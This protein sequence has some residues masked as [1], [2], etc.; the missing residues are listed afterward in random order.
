VQELN[1]FYRFHPALFVLDNDIAGFRWLNCISAEKCMLSFMRFSR[2]EEENLVIVANFA[3]IKQDFEIGVPIEG[4][5]YEVFNTDQSQYGG[6]GRTNEGFRETEDRE[7]DD[8]PHS[9]KMSAAPL[10]LS[11]FAYEPYTEE[12]LNDLQRKKESQIKKRLAEEKSAAKRKAF[13]EIKELE[14][15]VAATRAALEKR[16]KEEIAAAEKKAAAELDRLFKKDRDQ[17]KNV[18]KLKAGKINSTKS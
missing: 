16:G 12:E 1:A 15:D 17:R 18:D 9:F 10:S 13:K 11:V 3:N 2:K 4:K 8:C 7:A 14:K 6:S 5:Y